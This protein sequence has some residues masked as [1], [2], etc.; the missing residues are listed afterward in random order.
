VMS[1]GRCTVPVFEQ[2]FDHFQSGAG[3]LD[4]RPRRAGSTTGVDRARET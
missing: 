4:P 2:V 3:D 1:V